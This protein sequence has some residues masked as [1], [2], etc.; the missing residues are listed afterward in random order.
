M[1]L[2]FVPILTG[3]ALK[4]KGV[5][6]LLDAVNLYLP[7]PSEV[8]NFALH[9]TEE[10]KPATKVLMS[11]ERSDRHPFVGLAFKLEAGRF[12]Q[13]TYMRI[14]QGMLKKGTYIYNTRTGRKV[15][16]S[17]LVRMHSDEMEEIDEALAGDIVALFGVD[18]ASGDT[19]V[20]Q[21]EPKI[22]MESI[23]VPDP[24]ISMSMKAASKDSMDNFMKAITRFTKEDPTFRSN[25]DEE[26]RE[27]IVSGM[28]EL[29]LEIYAQRMEREY[30]CPVVLGKPK[31]AFRETIT[32]SCPFDYLHKKQSGGAGQF[33]CVQGLLEPLPP[34]QNT[35]IIFS[36]ETSGPNI[37][38]QFVPSIRKGFEKSCES[39]PLSGHKVAG[40]KFRLQDG[41]HHIVDSN[42]IAFTLAAMGAMR[43]VFDMGRWQILEPIMTVEVSCPAEFQGEIIGQVTRRSGVLLSTNE[44][45]NWFTINAEV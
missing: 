40:V 26:S 43:Q 33:G 9:E 10:G 34:E 23:Y 25:W 6:P 3:S 38:K 8:K 19:F 45:D 36:D 39:G 17:R 44:T 14:Y 41:K 15:K 5:Q 32:K 35:K 11:P 28:G 13:L 30:N 4:N 29:H 18:C 12:G 21:K 16:A 37:P 2:K 31:V 27:T 1:N 24:V 42:D 22:S 20:A 7:N